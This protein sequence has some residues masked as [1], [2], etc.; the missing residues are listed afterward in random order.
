MPID[1]KPVLEEDDEAR[2]RLG[3]PH[4]ALGYIGFVDRKHLYLMHRIVEGQT[5]N[6]HVYTLRYRVE[7]VPSDLR[8][9]QG[10]PVH[11]GF[12]VSYADPTRSDRRRGR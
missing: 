3:D 10:F 1:T 5:K 11:G 8:I 4:V 6:S 7:D 9:G 12:H 2:L